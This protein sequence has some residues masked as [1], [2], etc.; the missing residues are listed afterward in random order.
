MQRTIKDLVVGF[1]AF[2]ML[3]M[4]FIWLTSIGLLIPEQIIAW[5][6]NSPNPQLALYSFGALASSTMLGLLRLGLVV[7]KLK[8]FVPDEAMRYVAGLPLWLIFLFIILSSGALFMVFPACQTPGS[9]TFDVSG[10]EIMHPSESLV[11]R[12]GETLFI[13]AQPI[14]QNVRLHC[15]WQYAGNAFQTLG[16]LEGCNVEMTFSQ[17]PGDGYLTLLASYDFCNQGNLFSIPV[18][19]Q[20]P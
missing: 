7:P 10:R 11:V 12:P 13:K 9:V 17:K 15:K 20:E 1:I 6:K 18:K 14:E 4:C 19:V 5:L 16:G 3:A 2:I 8:T